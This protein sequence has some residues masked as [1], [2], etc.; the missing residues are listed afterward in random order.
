MVGPFIFIGTHRLKDGAFESFQ[1]DSKAL[2]EVVESNEPRMIAF[3]L[4][5]NAE[6]TEVSVV[7]V[8]P[9]AESM[10]LHM[11]VVHQHIT[12][13]YA[14]SLEATTSMQVYGPPSH[15]VLA[16]MTQLASEGAPVGVKPR[17]LAGFTRSA[18]AD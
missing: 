2:A 3:N 9:D 7:Q 12:D 4:F 16:M 15:E 13:A 1:A 11:Q 8:H 14:N 6:G 18:A 17:H 5:A 10:M